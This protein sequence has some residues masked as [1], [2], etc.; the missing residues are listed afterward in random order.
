MLID[1]L[2]NEVRLS[3]LIKFDV[4]PH[5]IKKVMEDGIAMGHYK[6]NPDNVKMLEYRS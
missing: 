4:Q 3:Q 2:F 6:R 5:I 1:D